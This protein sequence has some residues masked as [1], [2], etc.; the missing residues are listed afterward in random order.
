[1]WAGLAQ[2][3]CCPAC[4]AEVVPLMDA[5]GELVRLALLQNSEIAVGEDIPLLTELGGVAGVLRY[6]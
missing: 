4:G 6:G 3:E 2:T 1:M 5:V